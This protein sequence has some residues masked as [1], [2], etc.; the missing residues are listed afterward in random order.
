MLKM[1]LCPWKNPS[2]NNNTKTSQESSQ[3]DN[4]ETEE[5][6]LDMFMCEN[7]D[8]NIMFPTEEE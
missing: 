2:L 7:G 1:L 6:E 4:E 5:S 8:Q 3:E